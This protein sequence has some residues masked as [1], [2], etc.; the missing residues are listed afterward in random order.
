MTIY[1]LLIA[2]AVLLALWAAADYLDLLPTHLL[3]NEA[4]VTFAAQAAAAIACLITPEGSNYT[5]AAFGLWLVL[6]LSWCGAIQ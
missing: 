2:A 4:S 1:W 5:V 6:F 3:G